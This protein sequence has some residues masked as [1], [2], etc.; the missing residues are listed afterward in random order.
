MG[1]AC[2]IRCDVLSL[3]SVV[4]L[5]MSENTTPPVIVCL[6]GVSWDYIEAADTLLLEGM[7][8]ARLS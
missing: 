2:F 7:W 4:K 5:T 3:N 1:G 6:D 8:H